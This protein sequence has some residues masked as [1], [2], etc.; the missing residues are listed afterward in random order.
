MK[1]LFTDLD[2]TLLKDD[3]TISPELKSSLLSILKQGHRLILTSGRPYNSI[4]AIKEALE[5]PNDGVMIN[6]YNGGF[7]LDCANNQILIEQRLLISDIPK[8]MTLAY[9]HGLHCQTYT[10]THIVIERK[11]KEIEEYI[12]HI[13]LPVIFTQ[14]AESVF[15]KGPFKM[16]AISYTSKGSLIALGRDISIATNGRL[17]TLFSN[18]NYLEILPATSGKGLGVAFLCKELGIPLCDSIAVGDAENDTSMIQIAGTGIAMKNSTDEL[19]KIANYITK[20]D[21]NHDGLIEVIENF[22]IS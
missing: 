1:L 8:I 19:K 9:A 21:N 2:G 5:L 17:T 11:T 4:L 10:D 13:Q 7:L 15:Q 22:I 12:K 18:D 6:A 3:K 14:H 16:M 20:T